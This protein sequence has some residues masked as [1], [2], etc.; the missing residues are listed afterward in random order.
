MTGEPYARRDGE[1]D[2]EWIARM[3]ADWPE[4]LRS[5]RLIAMIDENAAERRAAA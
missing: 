5:I 1:T 2:E 4:T 3:E